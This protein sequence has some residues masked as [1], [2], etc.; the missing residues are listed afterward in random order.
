MIWHLYLAYL[1]HIFEAKDKD[2]VLAGDIQVG[3]VDFQL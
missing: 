3:V 1:L 2:S